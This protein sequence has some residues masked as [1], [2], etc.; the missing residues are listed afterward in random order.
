ML[1][2]DLE[3]LQILQILN[4]HKVDYIV[5]GGVCAVLNG[6]PMATFDLDIVH[7]R[8]AENAVRL[9]AAH[10][11]MEAFYRLHPKRIEPKALHLESDGHHLFKTTL[12]A[13]D[14]LGTIDEGLGYEEL[15][16]TSVQLTIDENF[17]VRILT[18]AKLIEIKEK[19]GREKDRA[20]LPILRR[21]LEE[22]RKMEP[23]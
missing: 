21:T 22:L 7:A 20:M 23:Q 15:L 11:E 9:K 1:S 12:G 18:L 4:K 16:P 14:A 10:S 17:T 6:V 8:S 2:N 19:A 3:Y 13:F 5:V